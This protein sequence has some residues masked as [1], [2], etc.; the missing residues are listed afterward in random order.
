V[1]RYLELLRIQVKAAVLL[2]LQYRLDFFLQAGMSLFWSA[3]ALVPL[4]VLF[5]V[6]DSVAGWR[7]EEALVV[8]GFFMALKGV[9][10]G[11]IQP[12]LGNVVEHIRKGTLDFLLLKPAD[13]QF[14][15]STSKLDL[16]RATDVISGLALS[17]WAV[18]HAG[19]LPSVGHVALTLLLLLSALVIL[20]AIWILVVSL[21]FHVVKI[22]NL[23]YLIVSTFDAARWPSS[24]FRGVLAFIFTFVV[25]LGLMT[26]YPALALLGRIRALEVLTALGVAAAFLGVSRWVWLRS[27]RAYTGAGG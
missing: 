10:V 26:T 2:S 14:L 20:Y 27:L 8:V 13:A 21:S 7:S 9:L 15:L 22:D 23:S 24:V 25:P 1:G 18:H 4:L 16:A 17:A 3:T 19:Y 12:A 5:S 6:R 11:V